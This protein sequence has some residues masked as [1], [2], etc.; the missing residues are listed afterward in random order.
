MAVF[1]GVWRRLSVFGGLW[2]R[3]AAPLDDP[4]GTRRFLVAF[5]GCAFLMEKMRFREMA[6]FGGVWRYHEGSAGPPLTS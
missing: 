2:R 5:G 1:G 6:V 4:R 3:L